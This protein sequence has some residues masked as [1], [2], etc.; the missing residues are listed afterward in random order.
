MWNLAGGVGKKCVVED[1][2]PNWPKFT[3]FYDDKCQMFFLCL[4]WTAMILREKSI[5]EDGCRTPSWISG[6]LQQLQILA[7]TH[8]LK[9]LLGSC[10][11]NFILVA[12]TVM[13]IW[14]TI[15]E[16]DALL[17]I[18]FPAQFAV[19]STYRLF[20]E[21]N[22]EAFPNWHFPTVTFVLWSIRICYE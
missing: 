18:L 8:P 16:N 17:N 14:K 3:V 22:R 9:T 12:H 6:S 2:S 7:S 21:L 19:F 15:M 1:S 11:L 5:T 20:Q 13:I 10:L 4:I